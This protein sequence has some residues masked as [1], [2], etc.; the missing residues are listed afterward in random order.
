M[1]MALLGK[2]AMVLS[3][4]IVPDAIVEHDD[5]HTHEHMPERLSIPGFLRGSRW[6]AQ[7]GRPRYFVMYEV[8]DI[9]VLASAA[10]LERLNHPT[11]WTTKMM[12]HYRG[13]TR[14]L[15]TVAR[16]FGLGMGQS[17]LLIRFKPAPGKEVEVRE[18]LTQKELPDLPSKPGLASAH[19]FEAAIA[20]PVTNEQRIRGQDAAVDWALLVTG[21]SAERVATLLEGE[22][23]E[24]QF[25]RHGAS[26]FAGGIYRMEYSLME[27]EI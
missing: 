24:A 18:W 11:P 4:D 5:W 19:L 15:C 17:G 22:L 1:T 23:G 27:R 16:S 20:P 2:A 6:V 8:S 12:T 7:S 26:G 21:Y 14:G 25:E 13:M 9:G 10:Y 3:F